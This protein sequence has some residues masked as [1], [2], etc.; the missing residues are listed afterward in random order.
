MYDE[1]NVEDLFCTNF[2]FQNFSVND[3]KSIH[4]KSNDFS[5]HNGLQIIQNREIIRGVITNLTS[6][7]L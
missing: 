6:S 2:Y 3:I 5:F 1:S 7:Q 4:Y